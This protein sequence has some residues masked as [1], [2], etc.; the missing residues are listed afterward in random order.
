MG[1]GIHI[2]SP[3]INDKVEDADVTNMTDLKEWLKSMRQSGKKNGAQPISLS[4]IIKQSDF[5]PPDN[6]DNS[7]IFACVALNLGARVDM[8]LSDDHPDVTSERVQE[9]REVIDRIL[10]IE[11]INDLTGVYDS[12]PSSEEDSEDL[13]PILGLSDIPLPESSEGEAA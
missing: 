8:L 11:A 13:P 2:I 1:K 3:H 5:L 12:S 10:A 7:L 6:D 4:V 9:S